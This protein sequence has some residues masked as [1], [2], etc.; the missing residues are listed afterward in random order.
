MISNLL[1][2]C[3]GSV[4]ILFI[5]SLIMRLRK[6]HRTNIQ[7]LMTVNAKKFLTP[8]SLEILT[9]NPVTTDMFGGH[10]RDHINFIESHNVFLIAPTTASMISKIANGIADDIVSLSACVCIGSGTKLIV[11]PAMN[12]A[13]W[14][15]PFVQANVDKLKRSGAH[16]VGPSAGTEIVKFKEA[17]TAL[18]SDEEIIQKILEVS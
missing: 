5:P 14:N 16:F 13:M 12:S 2:G 3:T 4:G 11:A 9:G 7:V 8:Y 15:S 18:A 10:G 1:L 17:T 6:I